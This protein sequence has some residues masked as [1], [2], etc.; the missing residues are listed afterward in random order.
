MDYLIP[1]SKTKKSYNNFWINF[2]CQLL[3][4]Y[5]NEKTRVPTQATRC[6]AHVQRAWNKCASVHWP[7]LTTPVKYSSHFLISTSGQ[8]KLI[9]C[10]F[11]SVLTLPVTVTWIIFRD[12]EQ[13]QKIN[14]NGKELGRNS[15]VPIFFQI[16]CLY[17][18]HLSSGCW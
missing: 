5:K 18:L 8:G 6:A 2:V 10:T 3:N 15:R 16:K 11:L 4:T 12:G 14:F 7:Q 9:A 1:I 13:P 17:S